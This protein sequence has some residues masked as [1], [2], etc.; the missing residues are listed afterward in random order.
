MPRTRATTVAMTAAMMRRTSR[1][2]P[3]ARTP[4]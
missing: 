1:M 2:L 4:E 3:M